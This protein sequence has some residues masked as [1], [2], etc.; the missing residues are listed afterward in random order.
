MALT[1]V[2]KEGITGIDNS[3]DA[4]AITITSAE[5]IGIG[6]TPN[7][8]Y[9]KEVDI[10]SGTSNVRIKLANSTTGSSNTDGFDLIADGNGAYIWNRENDILVFATNND[11][12]LRIDSSG[13]FLLGA[14]V[15]GEASADDLTVAGSANTG[16]TIRAGTSNS[17]SIYMS[18]ATSGTGE[19]AGYIA[20]AHASD[21]M[22]FGTGAAASMS[23]DT[24]GIITKPRQPCFS[25]TADTTNIP[26]QTSTTVA[27]SGE[28]F[29]V[30]GNLDAN[31]FTAP[32]SGKYLFCF[33]FYFSSVDADHTTLDAHIKT[34]NKQYQVTFS[35]DHFLNS[36]SNFSIT[37][38]MICDMDAND[39]CIFTTY[40]QG[41]AAQTD[42]HSDS[43]V[44]GALIC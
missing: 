38:S 27:L 39:T 42:I 28:R 21:S 16:I 1:K 4:T 17:S 24:N 26:L 31:T 11:E 8:N 3:S 10:L 40:V 43:Q 13:R 22:S 14:T 44:S 32:I 7:S 36:D 29:D 33:M 12:K 41:G 37:G 19:Y 2:G 34:S 18:D 30:G 9:G 23:I 35:P 6:M 25:A 5:N 15:E 20:Y